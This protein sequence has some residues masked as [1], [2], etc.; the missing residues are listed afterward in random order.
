MLRGINVSGQKKINMGDLKKFYE[1]LDFKNVTTYIQSGNVVFECSDKNITAIKSAIE[2]KIKQLFDFDVAVFI[3]TK[4]ELRKLID[5]FPFSQKDID[6]SYVT[7][8][9][10]IPDPS[11][12]EELDK[13]KAPAEEFFISGREIYLFFPDGY[14]RCR[15][16]NNFIEKKMKLSATTRNWKTV[17]KLFELAEK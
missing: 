2:K 12:K 4:D 11:H 15:L 9:S 17:T 7:F 5:N 6:K 14:G 3:R 16:S 13:G 10:D 1:S 8:L